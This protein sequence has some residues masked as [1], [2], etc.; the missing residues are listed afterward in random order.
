MALKSLN[1]E[2]CI[3]QWGLISHR[4]RDTVFLRKSTKT[5]KLSTKTNALCQ[6]LESKHP[7][8]RWARSDTTLSLEL[9]RD[10]QSEPIISLGISNPGI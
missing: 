9:A 8:Q 2:T 1:Q 4:M 6:N 10:L 7:V 3:Y 5:L